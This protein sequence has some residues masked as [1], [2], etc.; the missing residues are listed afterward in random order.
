MDSDITPNDSEALGVYLPEEQTAVK[1]AEREETSTIASAVPI[2]EELLEWF[3]TQIAVCDSVTQAKLTAKTNKIS[4][5]SALNAHDIVH[6]LL[7]G[8]R[9]ELVARFEAHMERDSDGS[10][11]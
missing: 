6:R 2:I 5:E 4:I 10:E 8:K 9:D 3:D 7:K 11:E 1:D